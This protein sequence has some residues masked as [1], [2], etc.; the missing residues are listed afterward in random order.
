[1]TPP[2]A[3]DPELETASGASATTR[4][5]THD[6]ENE[7]ADAERDQEP[8]RCEQKKNPSGQRDERW[9]GIEPH[10]KRPGHV[11][12]LRAQQHHRE[13][14][15]DELHEN[16][17]RDQHVDDEAER[18]EAADDRDQAEHDQRHVRK[19]PRR[20]QPAEHGEEVAV[21]RRRVGDAGVAEQQGEHRAERR[22]QDQEGEHRRDAW[23]VEPFHEGRD[24]ELGFGMRVGGNE[25][26]PR[27]DAD[28]RKL[29]AK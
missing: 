21:A 29:M 10:P 7:R 24:D 26:A 16:P 25:L 22:P 5:K 8:A 14:L 17:G 13:H 6:T 27:N 12:P 18:Q 4:S 28:D 15:P 19:S 11:R 20:V 1:M 2:S 9:N 23:S 3:G